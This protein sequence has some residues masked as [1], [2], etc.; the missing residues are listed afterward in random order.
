MTDRRTDE[1]GQ[2]SPGTGMFADDLVTQERRGSA[3]VVR[4]A[5]LFGLARWKKTS[6][7]AEPEVKRMRNEG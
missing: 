2:E 5:V 3:K 7:G 4:P 6:Y 1:A